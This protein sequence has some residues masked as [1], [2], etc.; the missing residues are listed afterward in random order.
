VDAL[1]RIEIF[2]ETKDTKEFIVAMQGYFHAM[3]FQGGSAGIGR[4]FFS[5]LFHS[6]LGEPIK[7]H[8]DIDVLAMSLDREQFTTRTAADLNL[9]LSVQN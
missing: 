6:V 9:N 3:P 5:A 1:K 7:L 8:P 4:I 2:R